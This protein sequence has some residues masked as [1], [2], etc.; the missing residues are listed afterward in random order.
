MQFSGTYFFMQQYDPQIHAC[1]SIDDLLSL[2]EN[3]HRMNPL[4]S[5]SIF[6][7]ENPGG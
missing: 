6:L 5:L 7:L 2:Q 1:F 4:Q 3:T